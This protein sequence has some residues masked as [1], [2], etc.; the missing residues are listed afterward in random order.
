[1]SQTFCKRKNSNHTHRMLKSKFMSST[2]SKFSSEGRV[3]RKVAH[4]YIQEIAKSQREE[5]A[6]MKAKGKEC[7]MYINTK[8]AIFTG[9]LWKLKKTQ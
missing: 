9:R 6:A 3:Q 5:E 7:S 8:W 4:Q 1:M 2:I